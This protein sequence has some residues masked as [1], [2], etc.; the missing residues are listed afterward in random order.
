MATPTPAPKT[1]QQIPYTARAFTPAHSDL[2]QSAGVPAQLAN[3]QYIEALARIVYY[4][5]YP[6]F[7]VMTR[8]S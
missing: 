5:A 1:Q 8:T 4:W 7:D 3:E 6:D 2:A